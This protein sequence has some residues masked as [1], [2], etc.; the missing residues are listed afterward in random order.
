M[1]LAPGPVGLSETSP[2]SGGT[3]SSCTHIVVELQEATDGEEV[4]QRQTILEEQL[5][6]TVTIVD[7][8]HVHGI[9]KL[10]FLKILGFYKFTNSASYK[11]QQSP[12]LAEME[13]LFIGTR[14]MLLC[15]SYRT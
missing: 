10:S 2:R 6:K 3:G 8:S 1:R 5:D 13:G 4:L 15:S 14:I 9:V 7:K 11:S 12:L